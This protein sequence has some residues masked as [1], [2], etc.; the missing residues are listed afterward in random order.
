MNLGL[1]PGR[2]TPPPNGDIRGAQ[3]LYEFARVIYGSTDFELLA[4]NKGDPMNKLRWERASA[5][6]NGSFI[7]P[8]SLLGGRDEYDATPGQDMF[9]CRAYTDANRT[10]L[11]SFGKVG[12][13]LAGCRSALVSNGSQTTER[14]AM[15][16]LVLGR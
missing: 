9:V 4:A 5:T 13:N 1:H 16:V 2:T 3:C 12:P 7:P 14:A 10:T 8:G 6:A 15:D 11:E